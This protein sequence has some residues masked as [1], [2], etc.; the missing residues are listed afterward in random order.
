MSVSTPVASSAVNFSPAGELD[1]R[2][3]A[4][5]RT[6]NLGATSAPVFVLSPAS[7]GSNPAGGSTQSSSQLTL[8][9]IHPISLPPGSSHT[10]ADFVNSGSLGAISVH[11]TYSNFVTKY[12]VSQTFPPNLSLI[13]TCYFLFL[14]SSCLLHSSSFD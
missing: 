9:V 8:P 3:N 13:L 5:L 4:I 6:G 14:G 10:P 11:D 1:Q 7:S 12:P 2:V